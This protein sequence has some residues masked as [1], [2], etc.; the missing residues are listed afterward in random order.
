MRVTSPLARSMA[1]TVPLRQRVD[2]GPADIVGRYHRLAASD[3]D[4]Q[5]DIVALGPFG[6]V[7]RAVADL[8]AHGHRA[9]RDGIGGIGPRLAGGGNQPFGERR[10][11]GLIKQ[12]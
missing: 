6:F 7:N 8:H 1:A 12:R 2:I 11:G 5:S 9:D 10:Q 4:A 3:Q